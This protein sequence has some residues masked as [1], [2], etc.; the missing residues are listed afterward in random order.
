MSTLKQ[1]HY[2]YLKLMMVSAFKQVILYK[3]NAE[4]GIHIETATL[5]MHISCT[6]SVITGNDL[7]SRYEFIAKT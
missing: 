7:S 6:Q 1:P 3:H 5:H 4:D 2:T